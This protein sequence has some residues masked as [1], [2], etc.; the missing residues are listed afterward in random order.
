MHV[1]LVDT[2]YNINLIKKVLTSITCVD[3]S[4]YYCGKLYNL[5]SSYR[6]FRLIAT[7]FIFVNGNLQKSIMAIRR[8]IA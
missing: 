6:V 5:A 1:T 2:F 8:K 4:R 3:T 7:I